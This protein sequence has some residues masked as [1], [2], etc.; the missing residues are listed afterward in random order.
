MT[1][2]LFRNT[3]HRSVDPTS[4]SAVSACATDNI[5]PLL[6]WDASSE[7]YAKS[8][9]P[10]TN[11]AIN[12]LL[13]ALEVFPGAFLLDVCCGTGALAAA[14]VGRGAKVVGV[15]LSAR[16]LDIAKAQH[17]HIRFE[18]GDAEALTIPDACFDYASMSFGLLHLNQPLRA[19]REA[20]RVL[21]ESGRFACAIW[22]IPERAVGFKI[23]LSAIK[24]FGEVELDTPSIG[25]FFRF[26]DSTFA[27]TSL[28]AAGFS[29]V[30]T[31]ELELV[32]QLPSAEEFFDAFLYGTARTGGLLRAQPEAALYAIRKRA[33]DDV[34]NFALSDGSLS[35]PMAAKLY[36]A[37]K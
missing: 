25:D 8:F 19:L 10:I 7:Y 31:Q 24:E 12:E 36:C 37:Q 3:N 22:D 26:A 14:A 35:V 32:W 30:E 17:P 9:S 27:Q 6:S 28:V 23:I 16:M 18:L 5:E 21:V 11:Q 20:S 33:L 29:S 34:A 4:A 2:A 13:D 15:D 1:T